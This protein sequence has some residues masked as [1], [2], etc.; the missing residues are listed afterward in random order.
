MRQVRKGLPFSALLRGGL[1]IR[2]HYSFD[3]YWTAKLVFYFLQKFSYTEAVTD[4]I[5]K[6]SA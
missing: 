1:S 4:A 6:H 3:A 5:C 2:E